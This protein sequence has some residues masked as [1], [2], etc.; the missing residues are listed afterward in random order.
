MTLINNTLLRLVS[1]PLLFESKN[2]HWMD[3][4]PESAH[5]LVLI[6]LKFRLINIQCV[7]NCRGRVE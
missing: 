6:L 3:W 1:L 5:F 2:P 7:I 4:L